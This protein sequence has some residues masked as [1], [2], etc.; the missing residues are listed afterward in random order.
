VSEENGQ[1]KI[2]KFIDWLVNKVLPKK[3][4]IMVF[5]TIFCFIGKLDGTT[6][7]YLA[8]IYLGGNVVQKFAGLIKP[9]ELK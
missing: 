9:K 2:S 4:A 1:R 8:M 5:A 6:W 3:L 7:S